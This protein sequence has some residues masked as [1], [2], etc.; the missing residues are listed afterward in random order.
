LLSRIIIKK[1]QHI[2][3]VND[4]GSKTAKIVKRDIIYHHIA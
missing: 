3:N 4:D 1:Q 2:H